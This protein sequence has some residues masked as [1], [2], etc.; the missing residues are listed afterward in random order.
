MVILS[1]LVLRLA[2]SKFNILK[3]CNVELFEIKHFTNGY[4]EKSIS[5]ST[6]LD[7]I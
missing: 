4:N 1:L 7:M 3:N 5:G 2:N 6:E